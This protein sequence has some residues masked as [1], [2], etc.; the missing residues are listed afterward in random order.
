M[1]G[2][3]ERALT[4]S[5]REQLGSWQRSDQR[6]QFVRARIVLVAE[7]A[8]SAAAVARAVG[9]HVQTARD[10]LR[11]FRTT[12]LAGLA[13][14]PRPGLPRRFGEAVT[15]TL[16][17][18]R[19]E[20]PDVSGGDAGRW[21][22]ETAAPALAARRGE[23][24]SRET[25]R[26]LLRRRRD[27]WQRAQEWSVSPD[28]QD[29]FQKSGAPAGL[30]GSRRSR[31]RGQG[32]SLMKAGSCSG[33]TARRAGRRARDRGASPRTRPGNT[34][35]VRQGVRWTRGW[36]RF[37]ARA[38]QSGTQPGIRRRRGRSSTA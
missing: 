5:E 33:R 21:T 35:S 20:R 16:S 28:P 29:A 4:P 7:T 27:S 2:V 1:S 18:L 30:P 31:R 19:H 14:K 26:R 11:T 36:T 37:D 3:L 8:P 13:P 15:A 10:V 17:E 25:G 38:A 6:V 32:G 34:A 24:I 22:V 9:V 12:G 23:P